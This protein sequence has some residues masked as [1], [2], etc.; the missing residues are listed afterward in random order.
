MKSSN[1]KKLE[2]EKGM[3]EIEL[4]FI[5]RMSEVFKNQQSHVTY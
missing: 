2:G 3:C 1:L 4:P 5:S